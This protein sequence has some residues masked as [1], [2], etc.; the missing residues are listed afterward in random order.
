MST[1]V[2]Y[3]F[4]GDVATLTL[5]RPDA[6]NAMSVALLAALESAALRAVEDKARAVLITGSGDRFFSCGGDLAEIV[7]ASDRAAYLDQGLKHLH[8]AFVALCEMDAPVVMA[9]NGQAAGGGMSLALAGDY[10]IATPEVTLTPAYAAIGM[11]PDGGLTASLSRQ[12]GVQRA[13]SIILRN[14]KLT[15]NEALDLG[16]V[17]EIVPKWTLKNRGRELADAFALGPTLA[18]GKTKRLCQ[19]ALHTSLSGQLDAEADAIRTSIATEDNEVA[20]RA[21]LEKRRPKF[22]GR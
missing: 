11:S 9:L 16:L 17:A 1:P 21:F 10:A 7:N 18:Y 14:R 4:S 15:A 3:D 20:M 13:K 22:A 19:S 8:G 2:L 12:V 5:H 6:A